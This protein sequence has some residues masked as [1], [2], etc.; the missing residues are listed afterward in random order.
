MLWTFISVAFASELN[1]QG[2]AGHL[3][4]LWQRNIY[5]K[6]T[7]AIPWTLTYGTSSSYFHS[8]L[9]RRLTTGDIVWTTWT[10]LLFCWYSKALQKRQAKCSKNWMSSSSFLNRCW[11]GW[12]R[13]NQL[14][15]GCLPLWCVFHTYFESYLF[16][17][18]FLCLFV[19]CYLCFLIIGLTWLFLE[20]AWI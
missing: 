9:K 11:T 3:L 15:A 7:K 18:Y 20:K 4:R 2:R 1:C 17:C 12:I 14:C 5:Q 16:S 8:A 6:L 19:L 10:R 13:V